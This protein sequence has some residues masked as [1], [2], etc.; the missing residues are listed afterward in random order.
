MR[1]ILSLASFRLNNG[2]RLCKLVKVRTSDL[3]LSHAGKSF[4][5]FITVPIA[6]TPSSSNMMIVVVPA[7]FFLLSRSHH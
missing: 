4:P 5:N 7:F 3:S 6:G 1:G 2:T